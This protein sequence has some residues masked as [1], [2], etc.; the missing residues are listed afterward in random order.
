[1]TN[2]LAQDF[3]KFSDRSPRKDSTEVFFGFIHT[4]GF[5]LKGKNGGSLEGSSSFGGLVEGGLNY[6]NK[7]YFGMLFSM[8]K[9]NTRAHVTLD[10]G[11]PEDHISSFLFS[12]LEFVTRYNFLPYSFTPYVE[13]AIGL[14]YIDSGVSSG[15]SNDK[16]WWDPKSG[17]YICGNYP[18]YSKT[19][20]SSSL[21][22]GLRYEVTKTAIVKF[23]GNYRYYHYGDASNTPH[24]FSFGFSI[25]YLIN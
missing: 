7:L 6:T 14:T 1:M 13:G 22:T 21:G 15:Q 12:T 19:M 18:T 3:N 24:L 8:S 2:L 9:S 4:D 25:G 16:C 11:V 10:T 23:G 20:F 5:K 17:K